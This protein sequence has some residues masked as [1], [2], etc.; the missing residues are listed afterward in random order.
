[1]IEVVRRNISSVMTEQ[2]TY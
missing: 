1:M 2:L